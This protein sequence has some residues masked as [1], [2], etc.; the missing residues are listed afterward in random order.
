M[1]HHMGRQLA[2]QLSAK[3]V[4]DG[5]LA[6]RQ[7]HIGHEAIITGNRAHHDHS[8]T[9][10]RMFGDCCFNFSKLHAKT[11]NFDLLI[12]S[13]EVFQLTIGRTAR[14]IAGTIQA[15]SRPEWILDE[16]VLPSVRGG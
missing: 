5:G 8:F 13:T 15:F 10:G 1:R 7:N 11:A 2:S 4:F 12:N 14:E 6:V 9:Y 3:L 16:S